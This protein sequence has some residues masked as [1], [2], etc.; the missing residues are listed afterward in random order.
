LVIGHCSTLSGI[1]SNFTVNSQSGKIGEMAEK[2]YI[3]LIILLISLVG[4]IAVIFLQ[5]RI[6][7]KRTKDLKHRMTFTASNLTEQMNMLLEL[8]PSLL[9]ARGENTIIQ[10]ALEQFMKLTGAMGVTCVPL[11]SYG[12]PQGVMRQG[13]LPVP[14]PDAW[15]EYLASPSI[16]GQCENCKNYKTLVS[17]CPLLQGPFSSALGLYCVPLRENGYTFGVINIYMPD[18]NRLSEDM[19]AFMVQIAD[20]I[21]LTLATAR[22]RR[23]ELSI[24][25]SLRTVHSKE[26]LNST[27]Q[28]LI[29]TIVE[30]HQAD[31]I[32]L[33]T[34]DLILEAKESAAIKQALSYG[35]ELS[36]EETKELSEVLRRV[37][38]DGREIFMDSR[39]GVP[40]RKQT[41]YRLIGI[42]LVGDTQTVFGALGVLWRG[43]KNIHVQTLDSVRRVSQLAAGYIQTAYNIADTIYQV[44]IDERVRLSRE[45]HDG[46]AQTLGFLKLQ[47]AQ[48]QSYLERG[49]FDRL[50]HAIHQC[51]ENL[52]E[53]Y[54]DAR[55]VIDGLRVTVRGS[56]KEN[57][58]GLDGWLRQVADDFQTNV[59]NDAI[60]INLSEIDPHIELPVEVHAQLIRIV[61]EALSNIRKHSGADQAWISCREKDG[62]LFLEIRDNGKGFSA[63]DIFSPS[64][65]GLRGMQERA[66]LI[67]ADYQ[68]VSRPGQGTSIRIRM[69][70][71][72]QQSREK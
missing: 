42:P 56:G 2:M 15:L 22:L 41:E 26:D 6:Y 14:L 11:D 46:L 71:A 49:E 60:H 3:L 23:Q 34:W 64:R 54:I 66:E 31:H 33:N 40:D 59:T 55:E 52:S 16:Q 5:W 10:V 63:E 8:I 68:V 70:L 69:P 39:A 36:D 7:D 50:Q 58:T 18:E 43:D 1:C 12:Q 25:E 17:Q 29:K 65:H 30:I 72:E 48:M 47:V 53:A 38:T 21:S 45:I 44:L 19:K 9:S 24:L 27:L 51:Y 13:Q 37:L 28:L 32:L 62:D 35:V 4:L 20:F 67:N 61:Q 57:F